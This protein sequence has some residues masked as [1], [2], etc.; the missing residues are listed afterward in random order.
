MTRILLFAAFIFPVAAHA[1]SFNARPGAWEMTTTTLMTGMPIPA[2]QL[3]KMPPEQRAKM[4]A[5][6][7]ARSGQPR[8][9]TYKHCVTQKDLDRN[10]LTK[11]DDGEDKCTKKVVSQSASKIVIEQSCPAPHASA[12]QMTFEAKTPETLVAT[13]DMA[14]GGAAG[15]VHVDIKGR[16]LGA[17]CAGIKDE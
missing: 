4:E 13:I 10:R 8:T 3:A 17:S 9:H 12:G 15:K 2:D 11:P 1:E 7:K 16:W 5:A 14:Q 6:M